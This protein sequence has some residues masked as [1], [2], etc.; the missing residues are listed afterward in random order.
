MIESTIYL[1]GMIVLLL[2][3]LLVSHALVWLARKLM[4]LPNTDY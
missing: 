3:G 1:L 2:V 4:G